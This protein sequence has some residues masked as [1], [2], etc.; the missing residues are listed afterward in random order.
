MSKNLDLLM[1]LNWAPSAEMNINHEE[2]DNILVQNHDNQKNG[3]GHIVGICQLVGLVVFG[4]KRQISMG[5]S[6]RNVLTCCV[7]KV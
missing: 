6:D 2:L 4:L 3:F 7:I 5:Q 1:V